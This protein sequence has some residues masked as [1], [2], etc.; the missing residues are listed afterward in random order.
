MLHFF[1]NRSSSVNDGSEVRKS[2]QASSSFD[3]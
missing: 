2:T 1:A 3:D